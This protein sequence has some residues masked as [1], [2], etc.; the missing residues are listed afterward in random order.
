MYPAR[1]AHR[2]RGPRRV[3]ATAEGRPCP[4]RRT[5]E[6]ESW[7]VEARQGGVDWD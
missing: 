5:V 1:D 7:T 2:G 3:S 6:P 4:S